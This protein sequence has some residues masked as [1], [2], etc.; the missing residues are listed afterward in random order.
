MEKLSPKNQSA[1][2][3]LDVVEYMAFCGNEPQRLQD[4][5]SALSMN[6]STVLRFLIALTDCGYVQQDSIT[7]RYSLTMKICYVANKVSTN[8]HL[9]DLALPTMKKVA[10]KYNESVCLAIEQDMT[11]VYIGVV[12]GPDQMIRTMQRIGSQ[13][14]MHCTGVGKLLLQNYNEGEIDQLIAK[15]GLARFTDNTITTKEA[16]M[17]ELR[18]VKKMDVAYDNEE[19]EVGARCIAVPIRDYT[20]R[21]VAAMSVTGPIFRMTDKMLAEKNEFL[22][23]SGAELSK[24]LGYH[25]SLPSV[26]QP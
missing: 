3:A 4:I 19:C 23:C 15:K 20:R 7:L 5:A 13:A 9:Y 24:L 12:W 11:V 6:T 14:P 25:A 16:L 10:A 22:L 26:W 21:I 17:T 18:I 1:V 8:I 2:K